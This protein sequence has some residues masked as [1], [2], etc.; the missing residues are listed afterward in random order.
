VKPKGAEL[1]EYLGP[2]ARADKSRGAGQSKGS[3]YE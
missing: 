3:S 2:L 1:N